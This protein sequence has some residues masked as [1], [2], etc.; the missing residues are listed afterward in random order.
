MKTEILKIKIKDLRLWDENPRFPEEFFKKSESEL[1]EFLFKKENK[2]MFDLAD[3][4]SENFSLIPIENLIVWKSE[5]G[6]IVL[7]GNRR[8][9]IYKLLNKP[10]MVS[11][12]KITSY[13]KEKSVQVQ[14]T[15]NFEV[16]CI[17]V[18]DKEE[19]LKYVKLKHLEKGYSNWQES[20]RINF[21][22]R[23]GISMNDKEIIKTEIIKIVRGLNLPRELID[24]VL[25]PGNLTTFYRIIAST[26]ASDYFNYIIKDDTLT[27]ENIELFKEKLILIIWQIVDKKDS[28]G[29]PINSR[30]LNTNDDIRK[31][32]DSLNLKK[33]YSILKEKIDNSYKEK[34]D[35]FGKKSKVFVLPNTNGSKNIKKTPI[36]LPDD[37]LFGKT[38]SLK[39]GAVNN[40]YRAIDRIYE[41][42]KSNDV[43]L[44]TVLPILGMSLRLILDIAAREYYLEHDKSKLTGNNCP[45]TIFLKEI[46]DKLK[47]GDSSKIVNTLSVSKTLNSNVNL[48]AFMNH[49]AHGSIHYTKSDILELS[50][51]IGEILECFFGK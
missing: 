15:A 39:Q 22:K 6:L 47:T 27:I 32:L 43:Y 37:K 28:E 26:P 13:F 8:V 19:G 44:G 38:L 42:N 16:E 20:E 2:K 41:Q 7:E 24:S 10:D 40:M 31:Y 23:I 48:E 18:E 29:N 17:V 46:K 14:V 35:L 5:Q 11:D 30:S 12:S 4:I 34:V 9:A 1:I 36:L 21:Q 33:N 51:A 45:F 3:S 25:G 49:Y 50:K